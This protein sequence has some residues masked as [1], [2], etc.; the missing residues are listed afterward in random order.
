MCWL[1]M[2]QKKNGLKNRTSHNVCNRNNFLNIIREQS[3][4]FGLEW[5]LYTYKICCLFVIQKNIC[6]SKIMLL[7]SVSE[8][9]GVVLKRN[10]HFVQHIYIKLH[11]IEYSTLL[12]VTL[13][14]Q[15]QFSH[16]KFYNI[17]HSVRE[18]SVFDSFNS[19]HGDEINQLNV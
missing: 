1:R 14:H 19:A 11:F 9:F 16:F 17:Y 13:T 18:G 15:L 6:F 7:Y 2:K 10:K 12:L 8:N 4:V 5:N 3:M